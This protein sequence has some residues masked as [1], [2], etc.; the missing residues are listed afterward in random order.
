MSIWER[1]SNLE[2]TYFWSPNYSLYKVI[3]GG[4]L[5]KYTRI[6]LC[7]NVVSKINIK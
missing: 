6:S 1:I 7:N 4:V 3:R 5:S 2:P